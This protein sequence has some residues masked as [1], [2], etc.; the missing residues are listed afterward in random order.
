MN[1]LVAVEVEACSAAAV[2]ADLTLLAG[3]CIAVATDHVAVTMVVCL[4]S[5]HPQTYAPEGTVDSRES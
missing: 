3:G 4:C 1:P 2:F 5:V